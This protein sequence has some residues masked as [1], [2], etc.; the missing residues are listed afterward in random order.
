MRK[1]TKIQLACAV[2]MAL[3]GACYAHAFNTL[4][5]ASASKL[6][7]GKWV[8]ITIPEDGMYEITY[9][10]LTAMGFSN[11]A[12]VKVYGSGGHRINELLDG[13]A[14]DDLKRVPILRMNNKI[15]FYG[16]GPVGYTISNYSTVPHFT[17]V[18]NPYSRVGCYFLTQESGEDTTPTKKTSVTVNNYVPTATSMGF[19][20]HENELISI[21]NSGKEMLGEDF[22]LNQ[23]LID[24]RMP[25]LADSTIVV[26]T[27][28]SAN[29]DQTS[30]ANAVIHSGGTTDTTVYTQSSSRIYEP[31]STSSVYYNS[32]FPYAQLK[33]THPAEE[34]QYEP[35]L[36]FSTDDYGVNMSRLDYFILTYQ[37]ENVVRADEDNQLLMGYAATRGTERFLLPNASTD[38]VVWSIDNTITPKVVTTNRYN[39]ETG[40]GLWFTSPGAN[41]SMY[42]AFDPT[43]T[44]KKIA[45]YEPVEN[46]NLHGMAVP[47]LLII[48]PKAF[49]GEAER[50][51]DLHRAV[52]NMTVAVVDH[53]QIF[54]EFSSGTR[55]AMAYRLLCKMLYDRDTEKN[56]FKNV[57]LF[58]PGTIDNRELMG[59]HPNTL[60]TYESDNSNYE[61]FSFVSDDFFAFLGDN[62]GTNIA[63]AKLSI[64]IGR[65]TCSDV[66]EAKSDVDKIVEY[67]ANPD[68]GVWRNNNLV[69]S[70]SP[71]RGLYMFQGEGYKNMI[72]GTLKTNMHVNTVHNSMYPRSSTEGNIEFERRTATI[73]NQQLSQFFKQGMY[74]ATYVGHA[75]PTT[76][77]KTNKMWTTADVA[78]TVYPH[79]PVMST[80]CCDVAHYDNDSRGIA[81]LMFHKRN[82][83]AI[84]LL[85]SSRMVAASSNDQLNRYFLSGLFSYDATGK[86]PTLGE[87]YMQSKLG[88]PTSDTNKMS[89][90]LLGDP[91]MKFN[92]PISRFIITGVNGTDMVDSTSLAKIKPL[93]EVEIQARVLDGEGNLDNDFNGDATVT[94][95]DKES[96]FT[97]L[98]L[99]EDDQTVTRDIYFNRAKLAEITGRVTNGLF[100]GSMVI[101]SSVSAVNENVLIRTYAH[102]DN[103]DYMVN[104]VTRQVKMLAFDQAAAI[105]DNTKPVI[106]SMYIN[107]AESFSTGAMVGSNAML[108]ISAS[109]DYAINVQGNSMENSMSLLLD[110]GKASYSDVVSYVTVEGDGKVIHIEFPMNHLSVGRHTLTYTVFDVSG[111]SATRT[112]S[113]IVGNSGDVTLVADKWPAYRNEDVNFDLETEMSGVSDV[114]VRVTDATG[115]LVWMTKTSS[116]PVSWDMKDRNGNRVPAGLYRYFGTYS[117]GSNYGGTPIKKLIVLDQLNAAAKE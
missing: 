83:G 111:N 22:L 108:Y 54:N 94:L 1:L 79:W 32:A 8:K 88:F 3:F 110:D 91:A 89:F 75:G 25:G 71:D 56:I 84:A 49:M 42:V 101:P 2:A 4:N 37:Q 65:I 93:T 103:S 43:K 34:G 72:D 5:Y 50:L 73:A 38:V 9:S 66:A 81:E 95:Y 14:V 18:F 55:D 115:N 97:T 27:A 67:Y 68:Y 64:G 113:F 19:F 31:S 87:A 21:S 109:D 78:S 61:K 17:R 74:F 35:I 41:V 58:G 60:L 114:T 112:I 96:L 40:N 70:D 59:E 6:S 57:L 13:S 39:N 82:G 117:D 48:S 52:D 7:E 26:H 106:T 30:Y 102:K 36:L 47:N 11:P 20:M 86:M 44:L 63:G 16:N 15:C 53:E 46:Q 23:V 76:F 77:T 80:A 62:S 69:F 24:Y 10:E 28:I 29:V 99:D 12:Q 85:A 107:D 98:T 116:F 92:Y 104:G 90:F 33:L 51:A 45:S 105:Q 100:T